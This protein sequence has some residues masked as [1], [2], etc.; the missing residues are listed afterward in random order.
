MTKTVDNYLDRITAWHAGQPLF[1]AT[2]AGLSTP[3]VDLQAFTAR[4]PEDF[5]IDEAIGVQLDVD[6]Q[7]I[8]RSRNIPVPIPDYYFSFDD[9]L[10][11]FDKGI[12]IGPYSS[13]FE[14]NRL[15]DDTYRRLLYAKIMANNWDGTVP[16]AK[17][18]Y[19]RFFIDPETHIIVQDNLDMSMTVGLAGKVP[20]NLFLTIFAGNYLPLKP[21]GVRAYYAI[22][23]INDA[24]L[25]GFD[26]NNESIR[27]FDDGAW[28]VD[29]DFIVQHGAPRVG[30]LDY[31]AD[32]DNI[33]FF[34]GLS[35]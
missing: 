22:T 7:W 1:R 15:D 3:V 33:Q 12:W 34:P 24:A 13:A 18:V 27:G 28:G 2:V 30:S 17:A 10:R 5:D 20:S 23:S 14:A 16:G 32:P 26:I 35:V 25:F 6:G 19:D 11:G 21:E 29:A 31:F 9:E 4:L 8:G